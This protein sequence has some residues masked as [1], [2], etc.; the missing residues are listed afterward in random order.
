MRRSDGLVRALTGAVLTVLV[1]MIALA[2]YGL[3][4]HAGDGDVAIVFGNTVRRDGRPSARLAARLGTA[5]RLWRDHRVRWLFVSGGIGREGHDQSRVMRDW[6]VA[7][8]IP[9]SAVVRDSLGINSAR[10]AA[11]A[12]AW[13][14]ANG[15]RRA[16][17]VTQYFHVA[18]ASLSCR[19][20]GIELAGASA[21][22][23]FEPRDVYSLARETIALPVYAVRSIAGGH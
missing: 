9:D 10:T 3:L 11:H 23:F 4:A 16:V 17:V 8:G 20:A 19:A 15:I 5:E 1:G 22:V 6:L 21:P 7:H 13:M 14:R 12:S 2:A 18:R